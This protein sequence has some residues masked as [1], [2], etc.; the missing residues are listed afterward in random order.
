MLYMT[1]HVVCDSEEGGVLGRVEGQQ[2]VRRAQR[3]I[4]ECAT[5]RQRLF[6]PHE[7]L[8]LGQTPTPSCN[9]QP[10]SLLGCTSPAQQ[11]H[12]AGLPRA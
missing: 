2:K 8:L 6:K 7:E 3:Q 9:G 12:L 11:H 5:L 4:R 10:A 1:N